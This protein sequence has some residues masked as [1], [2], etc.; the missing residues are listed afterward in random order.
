MKRIILASVLG[1]AASVATGPSSHGQG[2][3]L[4]SNYVGNNTT[5]VTW[6]NTGDPVTD[7][8]III[9]LYAGVGTLTD[10]SALTT[11]LGTAAIFNTISY[12][13]GWYD[14]GAVLIPTTM[15]TG[16]QTVTFQLR[17]GPFGTVRSALWQE[18]T[19]IVSVSLPANFMLNGPAALV[20]NL[21][22]PGTMVLAAVGAVT[23]LMFRRRK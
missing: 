16:S 23:L 10:S 3:I 21:P 2:N 12:G 13:G 17:A 20:A 8:S 19:A 7:T 5:Q 14:G 4:W 6:F 11:L 15:W 18:S 22:E 9:N 1:I